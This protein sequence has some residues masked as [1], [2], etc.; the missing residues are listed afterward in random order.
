MPKLLFAW[1][2]RVGKQNTRLRQVLWRI[3]VG[4]LRK[5]FRSATKNLSKIRSFPRWRRG[6]S[7]QIEWKKQCRIASLLRSFLKSKDCL[8]YSLP[9]RL[10]TISENM[11][12][13]RV[14]N[15]R[16]T[17]VLASTWL[18]GIWWN[19]RNWRRT[20]SWTPSLILSLSAPA[21]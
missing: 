8:Y 10:L 1:F 15:H 19:P 16:R 18:S 5:K 14:G 20:K 6:C 17:Q 2:M 4:R 9:V 12:F 3:T 11:Q 7:R 13:R 21:Q